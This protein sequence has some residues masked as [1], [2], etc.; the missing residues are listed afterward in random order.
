MFLKKIRKKK[1]YHPLIEQVTCF[2]CLRKPMRFECVLCLRSGRQRGVCSDKCIKS[3]WQQHEDNLSEHPPPRLEYQA[4][5]VLMRNHLR[6]DNRLLQ[7]LNRAHKHAVWLDLACHVS[8]KLLLL[9]LREKGEPPA[10]ALLAPP[11]PTGFPVVGTH[12]NKKKVR[13]KTKKSKH[14]NKKY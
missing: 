11:A 10:V 13:K 5:L 6:S 12:S 8:S 3:G 14:G 9:E 1:H 4:A 7:G 2:H